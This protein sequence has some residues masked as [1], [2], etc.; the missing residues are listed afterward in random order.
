VVRSRPVGVVEMKDE[1]EPDDK[2]LC[3]PLRDPHYMGF[4]SMQDIPQNIL[5]EIVEFFRV[6]KNLE[7]KKVVIGDFKDADHAVSLIE[8]AAAA[9]RAKYLE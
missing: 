8:R 7:E 4:E 3:V 6:Y 5:H 9:Y 2:I 1:G